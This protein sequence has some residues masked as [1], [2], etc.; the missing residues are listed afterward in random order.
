MEVRRLFRGGFWFSFS[1]K[2]TANNEAKKMNIS[3]MKSHCL[4]SAVV[5][6]EPG[7]SSG[8]TGVIPRPKPSTKLITAIPAQAPQY[9]APLLAAIGKPIIKVRVRKVHNNRASFVAVVDRKRRVCKSNRYLLLVLMSL[10]L[11]GVSGKNC[12]SFFSTCSTLNSSECAK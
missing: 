4:T 2:Q 5:I 6:V 11:T 7:V 8:G 3:P 9:S 10:G 1:V 12:F